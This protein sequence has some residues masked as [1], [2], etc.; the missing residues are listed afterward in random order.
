MPAESRHRRLRRSRDPANCVGAELGTCPSCAQVSP[1]FERTRGSFSSRS[2]ASREALT[3]EEGNCP[4]GLRNDPAKQSERGV[5]RRR[6][7]L[8]STTLSKPGPFQPNAD[9][10]EAGA[11]S[12]LTHRKAANVQGPNSWRSHH[13]ST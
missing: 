10:Q 9:V 3:P 6:P 13:R 1:Y 7:P 4:F 8:V 5:D 2:D 12:C 11:V